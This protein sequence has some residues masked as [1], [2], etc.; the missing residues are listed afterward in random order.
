[1]LI[2]CYP[3]EDIF[4]RV[5][6]MTE[7]IDPVLQQLDQLLDDDEVYQQ[8]RNDF[9]KR[10]RS[11]LVHG[12]HSTPVEVLLRMLIVKHLHQWS[13]QETEE[14]VDQNLI[15]RWFCRL[16]WAA[17]PD[18]TT[19][20]RWANTLQPETLHALNDRVVELARQAKVTQGRKL[21]LDATCVQT[22]IH[23]PTDSGLLVDSVRVLSRFVKRAKGLVSEQVR[24]VEQTCRSRL[25]SAKRVAQQLHRQLRRKGDDKEAEQKELYQKLVEIAEHMVQQA[26]QV[27]A[28]LSQQTQQQAKRL[29]SEAEAVL[30]L[31]KRVIAQTRSRV[32][33][34]KKVSSDQK[35]LSLFEPHTRA[36]PRHK[37]G[38]QVEF[39]R[40]AILDETEGGIVTRYQ[41]LE[42]PNEHGQAI[43]AVA[44]HVALFDH[45]PGTV[46]GDRGVHSPETE[47]RL[48]EAGV[49]RVAIPASGNLSEERQALE[50]TRSW[51]RGY[52]WR[53]GIE[54]RIA[55]LRRDYGW[56]TCRY[57]GQD[58]MERWLGLGVMASNLRH[59]AQA[60]RA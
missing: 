40:H 34:G 48:K 36:I 38:A 5:P 29:L 6:K 39:G 60:S 45:P 44:H 57:H 27:M 55:S 54:G 23:H 42:H 47:A 24:S 52:R 25:R 18:D 14:Q 41:I 21:R 28:A 2:D 16:Y 50:H 59:I 9:G 4:A 35:V 30:P 3:K 11:T 43:E 7:R 33:E 19:L 37:G 8:V 51:R 12:R 15:L 58:G 46:A 13:Y 56:R 1:M 31:V 32:I 17:V 20:I 22:E 10:Y 49:K 26:T 53:A